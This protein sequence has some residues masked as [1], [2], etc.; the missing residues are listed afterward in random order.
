MYK[1]QELVEY[2]KSFNLP[3]KTN[4]RVNS[5][6]FWERMGFQPAHYEVDRDFGENP[7]IWLP[8]GVS[9]QVDPN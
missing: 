9:E 1:R 2:A 6:D 7:Y 5:H 4:A 3:V 8:E